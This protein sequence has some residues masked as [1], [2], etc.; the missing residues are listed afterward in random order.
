MPIIKSIWIV[1]MKIIS[2]HYL[3][4]IGQHLQYKWRLLTLMLTIH[5]IPTG[6]FLDFNIQSQFMIHDVWWAGTAYWGSSVFCDLKCGLSQLWEEW[7]A[8]TGVIWLFCC[9]IQALRIIRSQFSLQNHITNIKSVLLVQWKNRM[10]FNGRFDLQKKWI[11][12]INF[13]AL[14]PTNEDKCIH[15]LQ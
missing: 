13:C 10:H 15:S 14:C 9:L 8:S 5:Q 6:S 7:T 2:R 12:C 3:H 11:I 4:I 1:F